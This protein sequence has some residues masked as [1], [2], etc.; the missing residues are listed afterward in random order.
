MHSAELK[1]LFN[2][3]SGNA[4]IGPSSL[5]APSQQLAST[6]RQYWTKFA[7]LGNP[8]LSGAAD[9]RE[10]SEARVQLLIPPVPTSESSADFFARHKCGFWV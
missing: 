5:P 7:R 3:N 10:L 6:V 9:W 8:N 4:T 2:L 1:Y